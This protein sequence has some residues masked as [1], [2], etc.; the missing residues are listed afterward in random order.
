MK[1]FMMTL[2]AVLC[3]TMTATVFTACGSDDDNNS[4]P[5]DP[6]TSCEM[7]VTLLTDDET[8]VSFDFYFKYYDE[9]GQIKSEKVVFDE[10][11]YEGRRTCTKTVTAKLPGVVGGLCEAKMKDGAGTGAKHYAR[12]FEVSFMSYTASKKS[13]NFYKPGWGYFVN[14]VYETLSDD[15]ARVMD[16]SCQFDSQ[17]TGSLGRWN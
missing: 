3:C 13:I 10:K 9:N 15:Y 6:P 5:Q 1:K 12:G 16:I 4:K 7:K 14:N 11:D 2:A 17:G 8:L